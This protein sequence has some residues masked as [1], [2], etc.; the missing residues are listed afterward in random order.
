MKSKHMEAFVRRSIKADT[1]APDILEL[2]RLVGQMSTTEMQ[3]FWMHFA[4]D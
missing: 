4:A 3:Q 2:Q 1:T